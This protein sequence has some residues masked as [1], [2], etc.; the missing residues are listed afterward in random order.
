MVIIHGNSLRLNKSNTLD[1]NIS[2]AKTSTCK[3]KKSRNPC[4]YSS[5]YEDIVKIACRSKHVAFKKPSNHSNNRSNKSVYPAV[6]IGLKVC[7][8]FVKMQYKYW[9][10]KTVCTVH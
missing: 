4:T 9:K 8:L 2:I 1:S 3:S 6:V 7:L 5:K 10:I